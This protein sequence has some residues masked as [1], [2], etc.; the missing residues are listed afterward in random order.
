MWAFTIPGSDGSKFISN[1]V[2]TSSE[3]YPSQ[4]QFIPANTSLEKG[5]TAQI[6]QG[7][8]K[9]VFQRDG[10]MT[11]VVFD[12][13]DDRSL[14]ITI[15]SIGYSIALPVPESSIPENPS[16]TV[17]PGNEKLCEF[18]KQFCKSVGIIGDVAG[19]LAT[20]GALTGVG[21]VAA[22][23]L[24][25][26]AL[27][28]KV[29]KYSCLALIGSDKDLVNE[30]A[31]E[32]TDKLG[33]WAFGKLAASNS[34][35][36]RQKII[37]A[38]NLQGET[39]SNRLVGKLVDSPNNSDKKIFDLTSSGIKFLAQLKAEQPNS[40]S[41]T[42][43][44]TLRRKLGIDFC[45][46]PRPAF[47]DASIST[48]AVPYKGSAVLTVKFLNPNNDS[49]RLT[50]QSDLFRGLGALTVPVPENM[51]KEGEMKFLLKI[52]AIS[53]AMELALL[54]VLLV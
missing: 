36:S 19:A 3:L 51:K 49:T 42:L 20:I 46:P 15:S 45:D 30:L 8:K 53:S 24:G 44:P 23:P 47:F 50:V 25:S 35:F 52:R 43:L 26:I 14:L 10:E 41:G 39:P 5:Y 27:V 31:D 17:P 4:V 7:G 13:T 37:K 33:G 21:I 18:A 34:V 48:T 11:P 32:F 9:I 2:A 40:S 1:I 29:V 16:T 38:L 12:M 54:P 28:S 22:G 6:S